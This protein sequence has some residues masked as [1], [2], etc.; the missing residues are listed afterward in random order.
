MYNPDVYGEEK[1]NS[2]KYACYNVLLGML[3]MFAPVLPHI[4]EEI[5]M[6]YF[7]KFENAKSIHTTQYLVLDEKFDE[8][9]IANGDKL[10]ELV[11]RVRQYKSENK[12]SLKAEIAE[13]TITSKITDFFKQAEPDLVGVCSIK[14][15]NYKDG[16]YDVELGKIIQPPV[17]VQN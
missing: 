12:A 13:I 17:D 2:A 15:M 1:C 11:S 5:Y 10:V 3:K 16:E 8:D 6:D 4:T 14:K 7:A 9:I